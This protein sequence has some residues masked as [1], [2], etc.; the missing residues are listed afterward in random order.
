MVEVKKRKMADPDLELFSK[1]DI[2]DKY[3]CY[4]YWAKQARLFGVKV[5]AL[6]S[7]NVA[8]VT[9]IVEAVMI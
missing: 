3:R 9:Y 5:I 1:S 4:A 7:A 2:G 6:I 8:L